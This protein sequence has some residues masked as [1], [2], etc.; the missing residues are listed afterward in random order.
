MA[1]SSNSR[2]SGLEASFGVRDFGLIEHTYEGHQ[3]F[4]E[5]G[6]KAPRWTSWRPW[7]IGRCFYG[8][9]NF[10]NADLRCAYFVWHDFELTIERATEFVKLLINE[11][12]C[13]SNEIA[14]LKS[15]AMPHQVLTCKNMAKEMELNWRKLYKILCQELLMM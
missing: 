3:M 9:P 1:S 8:C 13:M 10:L 12:K 4:C 7:S 2:S 5:C 6:L 14:A 15:Q 11:K